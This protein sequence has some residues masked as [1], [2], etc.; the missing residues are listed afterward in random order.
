MAY[1]AMQS[2]LV[3]PMCKFFS[4]SAAYGDERGE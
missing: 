4:L 2:D 1:L 3:N